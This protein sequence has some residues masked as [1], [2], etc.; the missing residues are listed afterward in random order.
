MAR[1]PIVMRFDANEA[2]NYR[3]IHNSVSGAIGVSTGPT[4]DRGRQ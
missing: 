2:I 4:L 3:L 1:L